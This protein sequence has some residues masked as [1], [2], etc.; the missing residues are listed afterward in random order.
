M[1]SFKGLN[2]I[3]SAF[4][5]NVKVYGATL[6]LVDSS[7]DGGQII[8]QVFIPNYNFTLKT[9]KT[10]SFIQNVILIII[11]EEL[12]NLFNQNYNRHFKFSGISNSASPTII[13][14][15]YKLLINDLIISKLYLND[16]TNMR[17]YA[18]NLFALD[19]IF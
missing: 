13:T 14:E 2:S 17:N 3:E 12:V 1:P 18:A 4:A 5:E 16:P 6:H 9:L 10:I 15:K 19:R 11:L 8:A 7:V